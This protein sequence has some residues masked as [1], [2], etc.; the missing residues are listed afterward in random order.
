MATERERPRRRRRAE[1]ELQT[2]SRR[3]IELDR[4]R[5][6]RAGETPQQTTRRRAADREYVRLRRR[7]LTGPT[8]S[9]DDATSAQRLHRRA[10]PRCVRY[11]TTSPTPIRITAS[12]LKYSLFNIHVRATFIWRL[13]LLYVVS[14]YGH[15]MRAFY[16]STCKHAI[17]LLHT[18]FGPVHRV[19]VIFITKCTRITHVKQIR[20][21][22]YEYIHTLCPKNVHLSIFLLSFL[23]LN[24]SVKN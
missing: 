21:S 5:R 23:L 15:A 11:L 14:S 12:M 1:T 9:S 4:S 13:C 3:A 18:R 20:R 10:R 17:V 2:V 7:R 16:F 24:N 19:A 6:R 8:Q 22:I